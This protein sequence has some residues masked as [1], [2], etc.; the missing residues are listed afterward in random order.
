MAEFP[1]DLIDPVC[2]LAGSG[3]GASREKFCRPAHTPEGDGV[4]SQAAEEEF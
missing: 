4:M 2:D 3:E 1:L